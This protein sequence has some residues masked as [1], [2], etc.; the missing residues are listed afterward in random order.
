MHKNTEKKNEIKKEVEDWVH[1]Q[2]VA[3]GNVTGIRL[4]CGRFD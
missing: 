3:Y 1:E 4:H 2:L